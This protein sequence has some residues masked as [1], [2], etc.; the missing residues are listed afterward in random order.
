MIHNISQENGS[1]EWWRIAIHSLTPSEDVPVG[2]G[3][4]GHGTSKEK[5][6]RLLMFK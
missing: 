5:L 6:F 4:N 2:C 3:Q 1:S